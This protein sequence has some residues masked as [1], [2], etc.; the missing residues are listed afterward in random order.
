[1]TEKS[2][3]EETCHVDVHQDVAHIPEVIDGRELFLLSVEYQ[4]LFIHEQSVPCSQNN[5]EVFAPAVRKDQL[6]GK[7]KQKYELE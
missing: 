2:D 3:E 1:M 7:Q 6:V 4:H 5:G